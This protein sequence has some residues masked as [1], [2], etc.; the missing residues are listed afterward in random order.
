[1]RLEYTLSVSV[2][3]NRKHSVSKLFSSLS[4]RESPDTLIVTAESSI[5]RF[6]PTSDTL[7]LPWQ[8]PSNKCTIPHD[9]SRAELGTEHPREERYREQVGRK[10]C[11]PSCRLATTYTPQ[12]ML[13]PTCGENAFHTSHRSQLIDPPSRTRIEGG[14]MYS[15]D[16][17]HLDSYHSK[18]Q[19]Q[20]R[21]TNCQGKS[22]VKACPVLIPSRPTPLTYISCVF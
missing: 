19:G 8:L 11:V 17:K 20:D 13:F 7:P 2:S 4:H 10:A 21:K 5:A 3:A 15:I 18:P 9:W 12:A 16:P 1:M 22:K 6:D 14:P